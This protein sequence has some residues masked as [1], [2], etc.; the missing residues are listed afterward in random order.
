MSEQ[1]E[2]TATP[3][4]KSVGFAPPPE[5]DLR[6]HHK[7]LH[8]IE[9]EKL[10]SN[11]FHRIPPELA[12]LE[13]RGKSSDPKP[14]TPPSKPTPKASTKKYKELGDLRALTIKDISVQNK[15]TELNFNY[16]TID[17]PIGPT[18]IIV[19]VKYAS[20]NS[21]DLGK[22]NKYI[23]NVSAAKVGLGYEFYGVIS[24]VGLNYQGETSQYHVGQRVFGVV[25]PLEK[26]GALSTSILVNPIRDILIVVDE[27]MDKKLKKKLETFQ[28]GSWGYKGE[29]KFDL[30]DDNEEEVE[31]QVKSGDKKEIE[32]DDNPYDTNPESTSTS[33]KEEEEEEVKLSPVTTSTSTKLSKP[34]P[35]PSSIEIPA[36]AL[37]T[38]FP[39]HY[40]R[41]KKALSHLPHATSLNI[42]INGAD[43]DLGITILQLLNSS[44][45]SHVTKLNIILVIRHSSI[46]H[47]EQL[48]HHFTS[49]RYYDPSVSKTI[50]LTPFDSPNEDL[51]LPGEKIPINYKKPTFFA[52]EIIDALLTEP[53][54]SRKITKQ[55]INNYKLDSIIDIIG[56]NKYFQTSSIKYDKLETLSFPYLTRISTSSS[57][58]ELFHSA[59]VEP[60][61]MKLLKPKSLG[62]SYVAC[63]KQGLSQPSY[64]VEDLIQESS[65]MI[66]SPW[67]MKWSVGLANAW[68]ARY[69]FFQ[70]IELEIKKEWILEGLDLYFNDEL[71]IRVDKCADWRKNFRS[72]IKEMK[73]SDKKVIFKVEDF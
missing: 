49:G 5:E 7:R 51:V 41:A 57:L 44:I 2:K 3:V 18:K 54:H 8:E 23:L 73:T 35:L 48:I 60:L 6:E 38:T 19:D 37:L 64:L 15:Q 1:P 20:L 22:V 67:T 72:I 31:Q 55:E 21:Y 40:C 10:K 4:K 11:P 45:Y 43:T 71:N 69:N 25:S 62:S 12:Y 32:G 14:I 26:K 9:Q 70:D 59:T 53:D 16:P 52:S 61:L 34:P 33:T 42:L 65:E 36:E 46:D 39:V 13:K 27:E 47:F 68:L 66:S 29:E 24:E 17:R 56:G 58:S 28:L 50:H 63:C 30:E